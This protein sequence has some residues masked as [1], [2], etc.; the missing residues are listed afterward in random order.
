VRFAGQ[1]R[2]RDL[3]RPPDRERGREKAG[4]A[5]REGEG[6]PLPALVNR[7]QSGESPQWSTLFDPDSHV[8]DSVGCARVLLR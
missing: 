7:P 4:K 3:V 8:L 6:P 1:W 2:I 5:G